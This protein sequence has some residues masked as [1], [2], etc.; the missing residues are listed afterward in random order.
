MSLPSMEQKEIFAMALGLS[1]TPW[2]VAEVTLD[3]TQKPGRLDTLSG[4]VLYAG[5]TKPVPGVLVTGAGTASSG[6]ST[7]NGSYE[8]RMPTGSSPVMT[9]SKTNDTPAANAVTTGDI[10]LIRRHVLNTA[11]LDSPFK[12]L[13]ADVNGDS[14]ITTGDILSIRRL[15][16]ALTNQ[17]PA[18]LWRF[19]PADY[20]LDPA[21]PFGAPR[22]IS[23]TNQMTDVSRL[24]FIA[25]KLGDANL[26]WTNQTGLLASGATGRTGVGLPSVNPNG[27]TLSV[28]SVSAAPGATVAVPVHVVGFSGVSTFQF[29]LHWDANQLGYANVD[30]FGVGG[31]AAGNFGRPSSGTLTVSWEDPTGQSSSLTDGSTL[32]VLHFQALGNA[33]SSSLVSINGSPT[34]VEVLDA[35]LAGVPVI[36]QAGTVSVSGGGVAPQVTTPPANQTVTEGQPVTFSV[37]ASGTA[38]LSYQWRKG[39]KDIIG[40]T[41]SSLTIAHVAPA[42]AGSYTVVVGNSSGPAIESTAA[43]LTVIPLGPIDPTKLNF[44]V[45]SVTVQPGGTVAVPVNVFHFVNVSTLQF[46]LHWDTN[47][48][49][50]AG[51][52]QFG[53][54]A[55]AT[56]NF[57]QP[58]PGVLTLSWEDPSGGSTS[59]PD[60]TTIFAVRLMAL[61]AGG[62]SS[63]VN[64]NGDPTPTEVLDGQLSPVP[65]VFLPGSR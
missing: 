15:I 7:T 17:M 24:N 20:T 32:F 50:Y 1:G 46:S 9:P 59:L 63:Q 22:S 13:A 36:T 40:A 34:P 29:S 3:L 33:G 4:T 11:P 49:A 56:G 8:V 21:N 65:L 55:L 42:D 58:G 48:F 6:S 23:R 62:T 14:Q 43:Q 39:G 51:L 12:L 25:V 61:G 53:L 44:Q 47:Q 37:V 19:V 16:L 2:E 60:Q 38:P 18:G 27:L 57:G 45:G 10:L 52:K 64:I 5:A 54:T 31:L 30:Q 35:Q 41:Q 28:A 26:S